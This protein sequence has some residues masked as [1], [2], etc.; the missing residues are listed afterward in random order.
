MAYPHEVDDSGVV[1]Q[2]NI[3]ANQAAGDA[4][5]AEAV[6]GREADTAPVNST[7]RDRAENRM[8]SGDQTDSKSVSSM[9]KAELQAEADRRGVE[10]ASGATKQDIIDAL[11]G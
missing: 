7:F 8:V 11:G 2:K 5:E 6:T 3:N 9:T 1:T 4:E 10:V